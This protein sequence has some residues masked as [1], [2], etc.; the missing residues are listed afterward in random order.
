MEFKDDEK[1][2]KK[3]LDA[4]SVR[5][6]PDS[7]MKD[8]EKEVMEKIKASKP[9]FPLGLGI[10]LGASLTCLAIA[11]MLYFVYLAPA[12]PRGGV[13]NISNHQEVIVI[14]PKST[15]ETISLSL[16]EE[17]DSFYDNLAQDLLLLEMLGEAEGLLDDFELLEVDMEF[18][19][20]TTPVVG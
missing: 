10:A 7:L 1:K 18:M 9:G 16:V 2:I 12:K 13:Q 6:P 3:I 14:R 20:Q 17:E 4:Y 19:S 5:K 8:Y 11:A 15:P